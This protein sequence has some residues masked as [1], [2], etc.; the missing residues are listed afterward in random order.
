MLNST[1]QESDITNHSPVPFTPSETPGADS[2]QPETP[3]E[4]VTPKN[5]NTPIGTPTQ[6]WI[7]PASEP[8]SISSGAFSPKDVFSGDSGYMTPSAQTPKID[9]PI[10]IE[11]MTPLTPS[12]EEGLIEEDDGDD[13]YRQ[14]TDKDIRYSFANS[15]NTIYY[16]NGKV[17]ATV[18]GALRESSITYP[19]NAVYECTMT[20]WQMHYTRKCKLPRVSDQMSKFFNRLNSDE[21]Y[22]EMAAHITLQCHKNPFSNTYKTVWV[23]MDDVFSTIVTSNVETLELMLQPKTIVIT[24]G[25]DVCNVCWTVQ[26]MLHMKNYDDDRAKFWHYFEKI[27]CERFTTYNGRLGGLTNKFIT[28]HQFCTSLKAL[29]VMA[30]DEEKE[31]RR[32]RYKRKRERDA[33]SAD[34]TTTDGDAGGDTTLS[35]GESVGAPESANEAEATDGETADVLMEVINEVVEESTDREYKYDDADV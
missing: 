4:S 28:Y 25:F 6:K 9:T 22:E 8:D 20:P 15:N 16:C 13:I 32:L 17:F 27:L 7:E 10:A 26:N 5:G 18:Y 29:L 33:E 11:D 2:V 23:N 21:L 35:E 14:A 31:K 3:V 19:E 24:Q 1:P 34:E 30:T 12:V